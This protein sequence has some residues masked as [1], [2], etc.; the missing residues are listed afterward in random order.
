MTVSELAAAIGADVG[1]DGG[2]EVT[3][4]ATLEAAEPGQVGFLA[5]RRY[6][7]QLGATKASAVIVAPGVKQDGVT[8]LKTA[9]PYFAFRKAVVALH[10]FRKHPFEGIHPKA[11]VD[12]TAV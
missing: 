2:V 12:E 11:Y 6:M 5:N 1:G 4:V 7:D 3:S 8:L 10:G 9:D